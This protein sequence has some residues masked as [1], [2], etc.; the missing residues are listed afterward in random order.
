MTLSFDRRY[1]EEGCR[2]LCGVDE[3]GRGPLAGPVVAAAVIMPEKGRI[4]NIDDSKKIKEPQRELL[5]ARIRERALSWAVGLASVEEIDRINILQATFLAMRRAVSGLSMRPDYL[6][7]D[8]RDFPA[9]VYPGTEG[10]LSGEAVVKGDAKSYAI[11]CASILAKVH[12]DKLMTEWA[13]AYPQYGFEKHKGYA[14]AHHIAML[15]QHGPCP[16]HR[17]KFIR[18][19]VNDAPGGQGE[20]F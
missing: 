9:F 1:R 4:N 10:T 5:A 3:A 8:G 13:E 16:L 11:A 17:R 2:L 12:R 18:N 15:R 19:F 20:L 14:A 7:V 6:L